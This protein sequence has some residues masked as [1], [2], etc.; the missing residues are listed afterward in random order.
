MLLEMINIS[1]VRRAVIYL[2]IMLCVLLVQNTILS[3]IPIFGVR[4]MILPVMAVAVGFFEGGVWGC[5]YGLILGLFSD[6]SLNGASVMMT[7]LFALFGFFAGA[8]P[9]FFIN[10]R[11]TS[12]VCLSLA[13][14]VV[15]VLAQLLT[16][17]AFTGSAVAPALLTAA[18]QTLWSIPFIFALYY[19][20]RAVSR[21]DLSK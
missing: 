16:A 13:A 5:V 2:G 18:L 19:P 11:L 21:L 9:M 3:R 12:F 4:A 7:V 17:V 14:L 10:R 6:M 8:L 15:T 20:C 1:K